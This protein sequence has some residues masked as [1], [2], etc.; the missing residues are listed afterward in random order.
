[1][2]SSYKYAE[3]ICSNET[4]SFF[5]QQLNTTGKYIHQFIPSANG[6]DSTVELNL[7]VNPAPNIKVTA[8]PT[9][10]A[11]Q[12]D[13]QL[14][15]ETNSSI[16]DIVWRPAEVLNNPN[17]KNPIAK[18]NEPTWFVAEVSN[19][20]DCKTSDSVLVSMKE[21]DCFYFPNTF[22]PN[23]NNR[24]DVF[25]PLGKFFKEIIIFRIF[26]RW[27][28]MVFETTDPKM[29]WDGTFK[30]QLLEPD[31]FFYYIEGI[32]IDGTK[33]FKKGDVTLIR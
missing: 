10:V 8:N 15:I 19:N 21:V 6:C 25:K 13:I 20:V 5:G 18:I 11:F 33:Q 3:T 2:N 32:C 17:L 24:N 27:G 7:T 31:V 28:S 16:S 22:T 29:G 23:G 30:G 9:K 14:N 26:D 4:Y 1:M 12:Q